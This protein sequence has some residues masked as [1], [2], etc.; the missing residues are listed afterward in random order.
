MRVEDFIQQIDQQQKNQD[1]LYH[2]VAVAFGL[3]DTA[4]WILYLVS[5]ADAEITQQ[6]L[7]RQSFFAKQTI[8]TCIAHL[9]R[10]GLVALVPIPGTRNH[11]RVC[12]TSAGQALAVCTT[13]RVR[14]A[15]L[16]AYGQL[17]EAELQAY[18]ETTR[19][20]TDCLRGEFEKIIQKERGAASAQTNK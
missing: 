20:L 19:R 18:L 10:D 6:D 11:K 3:S 15:E 1:S 13:A 9:A 2:A 5:E 8:N 16:A 4:M 17:S 7:C 12:L 14:E